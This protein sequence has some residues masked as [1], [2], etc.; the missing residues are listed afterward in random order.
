[1]DS[2]IKDARYPDLESFV[3]AATRPPV[4]PNNAPCVE[5]WDRQGN[6]EYADWEWSKAGTP[7]EAVIALRGGYPEGQAMV[8]RLLA[9]VADVELPQGFDRRRRLVRG[10]AGDSLDI[11]AVWRGRHDVAWTTARRRPTNVPS[12][13]TVVVNNIVHAG[14]KPAVIAWRGAV[15]VALSDLLEARGFRVAIVVGR[16]GRSSEQRGSGEKFSCRITVK[17]H[18]APM[19]ETTAAAATHPCVPRMLGIRWTWA[20]MHPDTDGGGNQVGEC[21]RDDGE[22][23]VSKEVHDNPSA[24]N[25][26]KELLGELTGAAG[27][28]AA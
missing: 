26:L 27:A 9:A 8:R 23:Y 19:D 16:G 25:R 18:G 15:A 12:F 4:N 3:A 2:L 24:V 14:E 17:D 1:M 20:N 21:I 22:L 5:K 11:S 13:I 10:D 28:A 6:S 7:K